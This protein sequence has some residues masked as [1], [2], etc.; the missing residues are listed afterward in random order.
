MEP[1]RGP[2][3]G[4]KGPALGSTKKRQNSRAFSKTQNAGGALKCTEECP[5]DSVFH[6]G[7]RGGGEGNVCASADAPLLGLRWV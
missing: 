5:G 6:S 3:G 1:L 4:H 7:S 2:G